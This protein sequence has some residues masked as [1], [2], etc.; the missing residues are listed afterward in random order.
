MASW[1]DG[2]APPMS[3]AIS[4]KEYP[5]YSGSSGGG[6]T[7][8]GLLGQHSG[9]APGQSRW[10]D[11]ITIAAV[12]PDMRITRVLDRLP[13]VVL[14]LEDSHPRQVWFAPHAVVASTNSTLY[15][16]FG[17][18]YEIAALSATGETA[19]VITRSWQRVAVTDADILAYIDGWGDRKSTRLNSSH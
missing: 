7:F 14:A 13:G 8:I 18:A 10:V 12:G 17:G 5:S 3:S 2:S 11:S 6:R 4:R 1:S 15:Y 19:K 16:G 9:P